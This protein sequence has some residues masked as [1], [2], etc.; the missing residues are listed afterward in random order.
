VIV[1]RN[2]MENGMNSKKNTSLSV[3]AISLSGLLIVVGSSAACEDDHDHGATGH[4][5]PFATC[6][7]IIQACHK[8]DVGEGP[9]HDCHDLAD[10]AKSDADCAAQKDHCL[11]TCVETDGGGGGSADAADQ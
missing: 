1:G 6:N 8:L 9:I 11:A 5:S 4:T 3:F 10:G 2:A 7:T